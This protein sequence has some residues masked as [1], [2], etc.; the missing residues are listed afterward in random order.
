MLR[1]DRASE[2]SEAGKA[3]A[4]HFLGLQGR[5]VGRECPGAQPR[6]TLLSRLCRSLGAG[7]PTHSHMASLKGVQD[8]WYP[9]SP[10]KGDFS[11]QTFSR[12]LQR[13]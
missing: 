11:S 3:G 12:I 13:T 1:V 2:D 9:A 5:P 7:L 8:R 4:R 10:G 6:A